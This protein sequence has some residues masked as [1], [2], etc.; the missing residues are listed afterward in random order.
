MYCPTISNKI[1]I[2]S[3]KWAYIIYDKKSILQYTVLLAMIRHH[4]VLSLATSVSWNI[5]HTL[6]IYFYLQIYSV[7]LQWVLTQTMLSLVCERARFDEMIC[8]AKHLAI[9]GDRLSSSTETLSAPIADTSYWIYITDTSILECTRGLWRY[10]A[11]IF[12]FHNYLVYW[13]R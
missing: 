4:N 1:E 3:T 12:E 13:H 2:L 11:C 7:Y 5:F 8:F 9:V 10:L 6:H